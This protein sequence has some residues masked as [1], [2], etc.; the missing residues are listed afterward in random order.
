MTNVVD[1][2]LVVHVRQTHL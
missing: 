2:T 1:K